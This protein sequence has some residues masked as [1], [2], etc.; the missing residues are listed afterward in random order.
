MRLG[1]SA[2]AVIVEDVIGDAAGNAAEL[3]SV[4]AEQSGSIATKTSHAKTAP[5]MSA[6][7]S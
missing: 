1:G 4:A 6:T 5:L 7:P 2:D 3:E